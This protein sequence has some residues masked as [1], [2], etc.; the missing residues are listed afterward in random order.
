MNLAIIAPKT[1]INSWVKQFNSI[2]K[3]INIFIWPDIPNYDIIDCVCLWK[4]PKGSLAKFNNLK[5]IYSMGAGVDH[6]VYDDSLPKNIPICRISDEKLAF[7]MTNYIITA[8]MFY[9]RRLLKYN[10]DKK[11]KVWDN[12]THPEIPVKIG[13]LGYGSLGSDAGDKLK[14]LGFDVIG[15]SLNKKQIDTTKIYY[16]DQIDE[17]L[18]KINILI[19]TVPYTSKTNNLLSSDLFKKLN[20][21]TYLI[22]VS[23][24]K[25]Q[26]E[27]DI[28]KYLE[29]GKLSGAFLDVFEEEPLP[30]SSP[31]WA[32]PKVKITPHIASLTYP[33]ESTYQV[34]DCFER[35][36][37]GLPLPQQ[38]SREK[39]Y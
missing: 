4:H 22:N 20:D 23:R 7:S 36:E 18:N 24:G 29:N 3:D 37:K 39:M 27:S 31:L 25:V 10:V 38:V 13:I 30:K 8:V 21:D 17:F 26:N 14:Y 19:C 34:L 15:Y 12:D 6:I 1:D 28:I 5:L 32:H 9:H 33:K 11:N 16:G 2:S 35:L